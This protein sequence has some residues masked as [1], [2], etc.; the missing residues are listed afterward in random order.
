MWLND[1]ATIVYLT[2]ILKPNVLFSYK[3]ANV[4][5]GPGRSGI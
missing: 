2:E 4:K 1:N 3:F 5:T